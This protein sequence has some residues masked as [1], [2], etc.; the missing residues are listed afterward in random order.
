MAATFDG[1]ARRRISRAVKRVEQWPPDGPLPPNSPGFSKPGDQNVQRLR[2]TSDDPGDI[3]TTA[4]VDYYPAVVR[5]YSTATGVWSDLTAFD[6]VKVF[7]PDGGTFATDDE[8]EARQVTDGTFGGRP[9]PVFEKITGGG[10]G[11]V[12]V[13]R[14]ETYFIVDDATGSNSPL[15][16]VCW[17]PGVVQSGTTT[18]DYADTATKV[19]LRTPHK[20]AVWPP[21]SVGAPYTTFR[22]D[23]LGYRP[24]TPTGETYAPDAGPSSTHPNNMESRPVYEFAG[25]DAAWGLTCTT[26]EDGHSQ[27]GP[28]LG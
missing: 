20:Y 14:I 28:V 4:G 2:I 27:I 25:Y 13:I 26:D 19:W 5:T 23:G 18:T 11:R 22:C 12:S 10:S 21:V 1:D 15:S 9:W 8:C 24:G 16:P 17:Y 6:A 3:E 7:D